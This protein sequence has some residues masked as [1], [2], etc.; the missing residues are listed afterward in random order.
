MKQIFLASVQKIIRSRHLDLAVLVGGI[1]V[2]CAQ[3]LS[4]M[5]QWTMW[6]D[7]AFSAYISRYSFADIF[8][9]TSGDVHPPLY[10]WILKV[11]SLLFG[12]SDIAFRSLSMLFGALAITFGFLLVKRLFGRKAAWIS[13]LFLIISPMLIRYG[14]ET[15]MYAMATAIA[16]SATY[17][18]VVAKGSKKMLPWIIYGIL[19]A[20]GLWTHYFIAVVWIAHWVWRAVVIWQGRFRGRHYL[21]QFFSRE[22]LIA[23]GLAIVLFVPWVKFMIDQL[24]D[25]QGGWF[26]IPPVGVHT[27]PDYLATILFF[28][29]HESVG[30]WMAIIFV[31]ISITLVVLLI[32]VYRHSSALQR[33]NYLLLICMSVVPVLMVFIISLPPLKSSFIERYLLPSVLSFSLLAAVLIAAMPRKRVPWAQIGAVVLVASALLMGVTHA[34]TIGNFNKSAGV[35]IQT[36]EVIAEIAKRSTGNEPII[37]RSPWLFYEAVFYETAQHSVYYL[38]ST[39]VIEGSGSLAMLQGNDS[40]NI[41]DLSAFA[42]SRPLVWYFGEP[43][44]KDIVAPAEGWTMVQSFR[45]DDPVTGKQRYQAMQFRTNAIEE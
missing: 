40:H 42:S 29:S 39:V 31:T 17:V 3:V 1:S 36:K 23:H 44:D 45:I 8:R 13:L 38:R 30:P 21:H 4:T 34:Q 20:A 19:L 18:L 7:E 27:L 26:W 5:S 22:W 15:R 28:R 24:L 41:T 25:I 35:S 33:Q 14:Q 16:I 43:G 12:T 10:Y 9:Y 6:F 11:W 2:Y 32:R 37:S